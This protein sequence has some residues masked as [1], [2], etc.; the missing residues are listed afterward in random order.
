LELFFTWQFNTSFMR[1]EF[2]PPLKGQNT[3]FENITG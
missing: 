1:K 2:T 3:V